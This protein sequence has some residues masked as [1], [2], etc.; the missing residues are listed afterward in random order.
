MLSKNGK[1]YWWCPG[2]GHNGKPLWAC[3]KPG[4]CTKNAGQPR[5]DKSGGKGGFSKQVLMAQLKERVFSDDEVESKMEAILAVCTPN[6]PCTNLQAI[7]HFY[8]NDGA[9]YF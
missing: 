8:E 1:T 2:P 3:H 7:E 6:I 4:T 5:Q 9:D